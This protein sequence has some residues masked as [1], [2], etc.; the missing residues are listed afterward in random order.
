MR[1]VRRRQL[2][3][4]AGGVAFAPLAA[5]DG[6]FAQAQSAAARVALLISGSLLIQSE[7]VGVF[8]HR[9]RELGYVESRNLI[10][11]IRGLEG[12]FERLPKLVD[13]IVQNRSA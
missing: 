1:Q 13:E 3:I 9:L 8:R 10:L 6:R 7:R 12:R 5:I 2:L 4:A 11:D